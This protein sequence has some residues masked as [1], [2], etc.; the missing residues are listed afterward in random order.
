MTSLKHAFL[1]DLDGTL[2]DSMPIHHEA[3]RRWHVRHEL[4]FDEEG[5]FEATA[6]RTNPEILADMLPGRPQ[7]EYDV[8]AEE[9]ER[10]YREGA[11]GRLQAIAGAL[12]LI[13]TARERNVGLAICTAASPANIEVALD[14]FPDLRRIDV[15]VYPQLGFRG[16]PHPDIFLEA[17]RQLGVPPAACVVFEDAPLG[18]EAAHRAGM[19]AVAL[20]TTLPAD[21]FAEFPN[22]VAIHADFTSLDIAALLQHEHTIRRDN[23]SIP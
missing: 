16:K 1:F 5:F 4:V 12:A 23:E 6:G 7:A 18:L 11:T 19:R 20:T 22:L 8:L 21:D 2:I 14:R 17:A 13:A 9:K 10:M 15:V 3:W